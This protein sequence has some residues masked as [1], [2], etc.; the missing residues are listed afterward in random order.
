VVR[1][2]RADTVHVRIRLQPAGARSVE[3]GQTVR[4]LPDVDRRAD[5]RATVSELAAR[6]DSTGGVEARVLLPG[7]AVA[8]RPGATGHA[9]VVV[10]RSNLL[11]ALWWGIRKRIRGDILL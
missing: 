4:L 9:E 8:F 5:R 10:G 2:Q 3:P 1:F 11:G 7:D 6:G